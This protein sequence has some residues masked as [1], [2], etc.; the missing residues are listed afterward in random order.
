MV[1]RATTDVDAAALTALVSSVARERIHLASTQGFT[2]EQTR[3][4][5]S[6]LRA[7]GGIALVGVE[8]DEVIGWV[9][10]APGPFEGLTHCGRLGMGLAMQARG[11]GHGRALLDR[12]LEVSFE[13]LER[14]E[15]E[16]L[17]ANDRAQRLYRRCGFV[18]EGRRRHARRT[19]HG[20]DDILI[21]GLLR[22]DYRRG[23]ATG[24]LP[25]P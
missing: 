17:A 10:I 16:V 21:F 14:V 7:S 23:A 12:A 1:I 13:R 2:L 6:A 5:L 19:E 11:Q 20:Y 25:R 9:D 15:L 18:E 3:D 24:D 4:Y 22:N 8:Q